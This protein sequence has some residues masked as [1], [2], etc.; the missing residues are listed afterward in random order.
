VGVITIVCIEDNPANLELVTRV[1]ESTG[2][3]R[4]IGVNDG[5]DGLAVVAKEKPALVLVD[6]DI[7]SMNGFEVARQIKNSRD[8][9]VAG[10]IVIAVSANV[11]KNEPQAALDAGCVAFIEKPFDI[12]EFRREIARVLGKS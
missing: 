1:L 6:L 3:Y 5:L 8:P 2:Q 7:P 11:L 9:A 4:V 10:A 12:H